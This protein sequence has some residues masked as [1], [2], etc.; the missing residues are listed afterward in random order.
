MVSYETIR[1]EASARNVERGVHQNSRAPT[2]ANRGPRRKPLISG[3]RPDLTKPQQP[4]QMLLSM[5][6]SCRSMARSSGVGPDACGT[7]GRGTVSPVEVR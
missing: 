6:L 5:R 3:R 7:P 1:S 4:V 2:L